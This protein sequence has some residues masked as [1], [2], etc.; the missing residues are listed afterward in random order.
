ARVRRTEQGTAPADAASSRASHT[1]TVER[2]HF[3][4]SGGEARASQFLRSGQAP[5]GSPDA[6]DAIAGGDAG[7]QTR[8]HGGQP[9][10][11]IRQSRA[12]RAEAFAG[13]VFE[14]SAPGSAR[15]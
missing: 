15:R 11:A 10:A 4:D 3:R 12:D 8:G 9:A 13:R 6:A 1:G 14:P 5:S 7:P 2:R